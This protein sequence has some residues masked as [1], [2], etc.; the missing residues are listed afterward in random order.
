MNYQAPLSNFKLFKLCAIHTCTLTYIHE[1]LNTLNYL[2]YLHSC[3]F[4]IIT[5]VVVMWAVNKND[6][7]K[8]NM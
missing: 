5:N 3:T 6:K 4:A 2:S 7:M 1:Y 8:H